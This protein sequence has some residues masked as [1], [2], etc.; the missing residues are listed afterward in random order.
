ML[1]T[2]VGCTLSNG[3]CRNKISW[4]LLGVQTELA[5]RVL[6][7]N[8]AWRNEMVMMMCV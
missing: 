8:I 4:I 6:G 5:L 1:D 7:H 2:N 3:G